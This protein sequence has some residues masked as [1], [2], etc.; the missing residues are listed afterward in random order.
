[1]VM[2]RIPF[3]RDAQTISIPHAGRLL[4]A[5][6]FSIQRA[7]S[8]FFFPKWLGW[9]RWLDPILALTPLGGQYVVL[10]RGTVGAR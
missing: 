2:R 10:A 3:D 4:R 6:G 7:R 1:M 8:L 5:G 9:L